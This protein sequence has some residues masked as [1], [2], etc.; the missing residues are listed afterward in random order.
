M[1]DSW[2]NHFNPKITAIGA[3]LLAESKNKFRDETNYNLAKTKWKMESKI[4][5]AKKEN[6]DEEREFEAG[7]NM[8]VEKIIKDRKNLIKVTH[9]FC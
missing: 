6:D 2:M 3:L 9:G 1:S 8:A 5:S 4:E 7:A